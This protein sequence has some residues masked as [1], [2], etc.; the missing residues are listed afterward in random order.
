MAATTPSTAPAVVHPLSTGAGRLALAGFLAGCRGLAREA[1]RLGRSPVQQLVPRQVWAAVLG[2]PCRLVITVAGAGVRGSG[3]RGVAI[4]RA[5]GAG[6][7]GWLRPAAGC[8][9][10]AGRS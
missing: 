3:D 7:F 2:P 4:A 5:R 1:R 8:R 10:A 9:V 6:C